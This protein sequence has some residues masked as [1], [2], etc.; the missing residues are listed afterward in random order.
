MKAPSR[1]SLSFKDNLKPESSLAALRD[2]RRIDQIW[3]KLVEDNPSIDTTSKRELFLKGLVVVWLLTS[4]AVSMAKLQMLSR[5]MKR[6]K[7]TNIKK[8]LARSL[9]SKTSAG[10]LLALLHDAG[11]KLELLAEAEKLLEALYQ[12]EFYPLLNIRSNHDDSRPRTA[13]M[14]AA[15]RRMHKTTGKWHD[16]EVADLTDIA[17]PDE[18]TTIDMVRSARRGIRS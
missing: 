7:E 1:G 9:S 18:E 10:K 2:D 14:R 15:S 17:F 12:D 4:V 5:Q 11:T 6:D 3:K 8:T 13:F 16:N